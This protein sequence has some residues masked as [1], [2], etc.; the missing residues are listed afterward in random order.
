MVSVKKVNLVY[1]NQAVQEIFEKI[2][3]TM[4]EKKAYIKSHGFD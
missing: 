2:E 3:T 4:N 1:K